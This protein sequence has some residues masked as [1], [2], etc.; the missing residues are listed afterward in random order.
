MQ[1]LVQTDSTVVVDS[2]EHA[3]VGTIAPQTDPGNT[4]SWSGGRLLKLTVDKVSGSANLGFA[5]LNGLV[6]GHP[7]SC[8]HGTTRLNY[9]HSVVIDLS[10]AQLHADDKYTFTLGECGIQPTS[11]ASAEGTFALR[12]LVL[13]S[14]APG[15]LAGSYAYRLTG[16]LL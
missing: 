13:P 8:K 2:T 12:A 6:S 16:S 7:V 3:F 4:K 14:N 15:N 11:D 1:V 9:F 5:L 10:S